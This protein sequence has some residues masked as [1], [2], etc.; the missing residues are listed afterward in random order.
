M[1]Y[2]SLDNADTVI[3]GGATLPVSK[4]RLCLLTFD[5]I[6]GGA[7]LLTLFEK[8]CPVSPKPRA[9]PRGRA[10][11]GPCRLP[12]PNIAA[13]GG[14]S[15]TFFITFFSYGPHRHRIAIR[16]IIHRQYSIENYA[17]LQRRTHHPQQKPS[18]ATL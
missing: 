18:S 6:T 16:A 15:Q 9:K 14:S 8:A 11:G 17:R 12:T 3:E 4:T 1:L 13:P 2:V 10:E 7:P 5:R